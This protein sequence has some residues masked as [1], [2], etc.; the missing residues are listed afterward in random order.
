VAFIHTGTDPV[1]EGTREALLTLGNGPRT[2]VS[3][4]H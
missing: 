2:R 1:G 4:S 3:S